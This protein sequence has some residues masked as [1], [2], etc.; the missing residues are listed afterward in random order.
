MCT[1]D[2]GLI[3][4]DWVQGRKKPY[5]DFNTQHMCRNFE[6][7]I[8]W[9]AQNAAHVPVDNLVRIGDETDLESLP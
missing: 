1:A 2:V 5:P 8:N 3:S 9:N 7:L 4:F 6:E